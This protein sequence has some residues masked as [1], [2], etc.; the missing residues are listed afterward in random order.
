MID[1]YVKLF[2][3]VLPVTSILLIPQIQGT[4]PGL[5]MSL[6]SP[7][8][9]LFARG[10]HI[11]TYCQWAILFVAAFLFSF[12]TSQLSLALSA[13]GHAAN[14][15]VR[16][17]ALEPL[18]S[19]IF[20][21]GL[22]LAVGFLTFI[23][24]AT[25]YKE[26]WDRYII[27]GGVILAAIGLA[28]WFCFLLT[29]SDFGFLSN[30][31]FGD[32]MD[33]SGS[34][35]QSITVAGRSLLRLKSLTGEPSMYAL[36]A[37]PYMAFCIARRHYKAASFIFLTLLLST[38]TS[39]LLGFAVFGL[40]M[41]LFNLR[42]FGSKIA[43]LLALVL[44]SLAFAFLFG[45]LIVQTV[46]EKLMLENI[47]G[48]DRFFNFRTNLDFWLNSGLPV[49]FFG[50]GWGT[51]RSTDM[52]STLLVNTGLAGLLSWMALFLLPTAVVRRDNR[53][54][55]VL[56]L[57][58]ITVL[59]I[60]FIAVPEY[61]YLTTW[62]FLGIL[63]RMSMNYPPLNRCRSSSGGFAVHRLQRQRANPAT[64]YGCLPSGNNA[65]TFFG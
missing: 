40:L 11:R 29:G 57:G 47:S 33:G 49:Q 54:P 43:G 52:F 14:L 13:H 10:E 61:A 1:Q 41:V 5:M 16:P 64:A 25:C 26:E 4:T 30:R 44:S 48:F 36:T 7:F 55:H 31:T 42:G 24:F 62:M 35:I 22:Y 50:I 59:T 38:S 8:V 32:G 12:L 21:Q 56:N 58:M 20:T 28:E 23:L 34:L 45:D 53:V 60:L 65:R 6:F 9:V 46:V 17:G 51:V 15:L 3:L 63:Y 27:A 18:R 19:T 39:A 37:F 2:A